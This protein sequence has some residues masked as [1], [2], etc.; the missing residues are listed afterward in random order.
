MR[1]FS[2]PASTV[3]YQRRDGEAIDGIFL[4]EEGLR[5]VEIVGN[6]YPLYERHDLGSLDYT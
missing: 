2:D 3:S 4:V 6:A 1:L 5:L